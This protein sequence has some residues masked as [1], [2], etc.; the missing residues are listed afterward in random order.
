METSHSHSFSFSPPSILFGGVVC[1]DGDARF[2]VVVV[3][4]C[5]CDGGLRGVV[6]KW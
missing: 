3:F 5:F 4:F 1:R 2:R 6:V